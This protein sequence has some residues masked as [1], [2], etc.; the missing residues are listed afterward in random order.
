MPEQVNC[1]LAQLNPRLLDKEANLERALSAIEEASRGGAELLV[2]PELFLAG[3]YMRERTKSEAESLEGPSLSRLAR[4][5]K[6]RGMLVVLGF[7]ELDGEAVYN[8]A[9]VIDADGRILGTHRKAHLYG[10]E[11]EYFAAG[12]R[13]PVFDTTVGRIGIQICFDVEFPETARLLALS[14]ARIL[15]SASA[16]MRP[17]EAHQEVYLRARAIENQVFHVLVNRVGREEDTDF[18]GRSGIADPLGN[19][20]VD[21]GEREGLFYA[22]I[23]TPLIHEAASTLKYLDKRRPE[24]YGGLTRESLSQ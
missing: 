14:G 5:A 3:Y 9:A 20:I 11:P 6:E 17:F 18:F 22:S 24:L 12:D 1:A 23:K 19:L 2:F 4:S 16:N 15:I 13:F 7:P 10:V 21:A 8:S